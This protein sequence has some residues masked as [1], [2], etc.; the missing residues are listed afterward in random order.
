MNRQWLSFR[1]TKWTLRVACPDMGGC[2]N[3]LYI[4]TIRTGSRL[5]LESKQVCL[6]LEF[7]GT[8]AVLAEL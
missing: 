7:K 2:I 3:T 4:T 5:T 8:A 1:G 6:V